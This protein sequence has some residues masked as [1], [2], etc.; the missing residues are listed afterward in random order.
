MLPEFSNTSL[1]ESESHSVLSDSLWPM[2][3]I[4]HGILQARLLE[5]VAFPFSM[6]SSQPRDWTQV[7]NIAGGF[8]TSWVTGKPK[9]TEWVADPF[10]SRSSWLRN[11][12]RVSYVAGRF[13]T[14]WA[15]REDMQLNIMYNN[16]GILTIRYIVAKFWRR[17]L[18]G[19]SKYLCI[20]WLQLRGM[21]CD[22]GSPSDQMWTVTWHTWYWL[23]IGWNLQVFQHDR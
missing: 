6:G 9:N 16:P 10:S 1:N 13:F 21:H 19:T 12:T 2:D 5:W 7:S 14:N 23:D 22:S 18:L 17:F 4:F 15:I 3:C 8:F 20:Y 11:Q